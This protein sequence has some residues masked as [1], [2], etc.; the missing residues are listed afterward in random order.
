MHDGHRRARARRSPALYARPQGPAGVEAPSAPDAE[1]PGGGELRETP[2]ARWRPLAI[3]E[4][5]VSR[6]KPTLLSSR[7]PPGQ[8][9]M[10]SCAR[11]G[12]ASAQRASR[13][14]RRRCARTRAVQKSYRQLL[15]GIVVS[16]AGRDRAKSGRQQREA[17]GCEKRICSTKLTDISVLPQLHALA[18]VWGS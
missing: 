14:W 1:G 18:H 16:C 13:M 8:E 3:R 2:P 9:H 10:N 6:R 11:A 17:L 5:R 12:P 4:A 15:P 7:A